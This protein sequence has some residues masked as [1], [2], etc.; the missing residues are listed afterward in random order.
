MKTL[1]N[2][3]SNELL[4]IDSST[5]ED[6]QLTAEVVQLGSGDIIPVPISISALDCQTITYLVNLEEDELQNANY[7]LRIKDALG[8]VISSTSIRVDGNK[9]PTRSYVVLDSG[10]G[11]SATGGSV[12]GGVS[13]S[14]SGAPVLMAKKRYYIQ[15][16]VEYNLYIPATNSPTSYDVFGLIDGLTFD[17]TTGLI[18]GIPTATEGLESMSLTVTNEFGHDT[19]LVFFQIVD[20]DTSILYPPDSFRVSEGR[21]ASYYFVEWDYLGYDGD[22]RYVKY[23][24]NGEFVYDIDN[25][26]N[27]SLRISAL[28]QNLPAAVNYFQVKFVDIDNTIISKSSDRLR[29]NGKEAAFIYRYEDV[30]KIDDS[31]AVPSIKPEKIYYIQKDVEFEFDLSKITY[32]NPVSWTF[33]SFF[34]TGGFT[35]GST[36]SVDG[37]FNEGTG[38]ATITALGDL[39]NFDDYGRAASVSATNVNG[40]SESIWIR[41]R[42]S[43]NNPNQIS[44]PI[45]VVLETVGEDF[46]TWDY[47]PYN[48]LIKVI[49]VYKNDVLVKTAFNSNSQGDIIGTGVDNTAGDIWKVRF[50]DEDGVFSPYSDEL[51]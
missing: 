14:S 24:R 45:N 33:A 49:E 1:T 19:G 50:M 26:T 32:N 12:G 34:S 28:Q 15:V 29:V 9:K 11:S 46:L 8:G 10:T 17:S 39:Y 18:S 16:G 48:R 21:R 43:E 22:V 7:L 20:H 38:I 5:S 42:F 13:V 4:F 47:Q 31:S 35:D 23:Y 41:F 36:Y 27:G 2:N 44:K 6:A 40:A 51:T 3:Q 30:S 25:G 37:S